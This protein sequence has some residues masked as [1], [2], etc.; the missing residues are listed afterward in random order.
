VRA[1]RWGLEAEPPPFSGLIVV[2]LLFA[3][4]SPCVLSWSRLGFCAGVVSDCLL[5][6]CCVFISEGK[7]GRGVEE[8][9]DG[10]M[11]WIWV[12]SVTLKTALE[13]DLHIVTLPARPESL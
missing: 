6:L 13:S 3:P 7:M 4:V 5:L 11:G 9:M 1:L 10:L 2:G 8:W 12:P